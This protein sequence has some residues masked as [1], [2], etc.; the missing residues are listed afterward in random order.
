M[1]TGWGRQVYTVYTWH[2]ELCVQTQEL[3]HKMWDK[4]NVWADMLNTLWGRQLII[5]NQCF[6]VFTP[7]T[8]CV[9]LLVG[10]LSTQ[11]L[12]P[13]LFHEQKGFIPNKSLIWLIYT[14]QWWSNTHKHSVL[15]STVSLLHT[16]FLPPD[17]RL[18]PPL[19]CLWH[20]L[21]YQ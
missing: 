2:Q 12:W 3:I 13:T 10:M 11:Q 20:L 7:R 14:V 6:S 16:G 9:A 8:F 19:Q 17:T 5:L 1:K 15:D 4:D 21:L 18:K